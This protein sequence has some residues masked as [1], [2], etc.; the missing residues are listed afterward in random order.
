VA[1]V[2]GRLA[3]AG[4]AEG[5]AGTTSRPNRSVVGPSCETQGM[6]PSAETS[7]EMTL[8]E[9]SELVGAHA[10]D[11]SLVDFSIGD[12]SFPD[13]CAQPFGDKGIVIIV[14]CVHGRAP[15]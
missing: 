15:V 13:E 9:S 1:L 7:E 6:G 14:I 4:G 10:G 3:L 11:A 5:L 8:C 12:Q 2:I